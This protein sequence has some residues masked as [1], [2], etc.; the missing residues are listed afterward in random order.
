MTKGGFT[1]A[2]PLAYSPPKGPTNQ[3]Q[4]GPGLHGDNYG[5]T[6]GPDSAGAT[7]GSKG[8]KGKIHSGGSQGRH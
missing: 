4:R 5:C 6:N 7:S 1:S 8:L 2:K 3:M